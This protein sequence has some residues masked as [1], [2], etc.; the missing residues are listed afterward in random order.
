M[1]D[2]EMARVLRGLNDRADCDDDCPAELYDCSWVV[3]YVILFQDNNNNHTL[4]MT[5]DGTT[6]V[7]YVVGTAPYYILLYIE[8]EVEAPVAY[9]SDI[10]RG[11]SLF[12]GAPFSISD[13]QI[14]IFCEWRSF[15]FRSNRVGSK[16]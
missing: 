3:G 9:R 12:Y 10:H 8:S 13:T 16:N 5:P 6:F 14:S 4:D 11:L 1:N 15:R 2:G 7:D